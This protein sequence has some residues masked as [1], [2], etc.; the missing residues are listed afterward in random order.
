M[1][2]WIYTKQFDFPIQ[3]LAVTA[4]IQWLT[5]S[6]FLRGNAIKIPRVHDTVLTALVSNGNASM[7]P[8]VYDTAA[9]ALVRLG[10]ASRPT[11][12][13]LYDTVVS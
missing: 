12:P 8:R 10:N 4:T 6:H 11:I 3:I 5:R 2:N 1:L 13:R 7:I 9:T